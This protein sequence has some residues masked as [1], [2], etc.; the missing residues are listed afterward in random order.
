MPEKILNTGSIP[1]ESML[2][3]IRCI[4]CGYPIGRVAVLFRQIRAKRV[5]ELLKGRMVIPTQT[6]I[7]AQLQIDMSDIFELLGIH[8]DC[9][10]VHLGTAMDFRDYY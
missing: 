10:R 3:P 9:C 4:T 1:I 6:M 5:A 7:D 8:L 2:V